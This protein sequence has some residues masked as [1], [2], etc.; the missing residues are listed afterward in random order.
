[1]NEWEGYADVEPAIRANPRIRD[2]CEAVATCE[3]DVEMIL[4][5]LRDVFRPGELDYAGRRWH[6]YRLVWSGSKPAEVGKQSNL[7]HGTVTNAIA[8]A[9]PLA[10][11]GARRAHE[12]L[13][14]KGNTAIDVPADGD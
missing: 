8:W 9:G 12:R 14:L 7:S 11:G 13:V 10:R 5:L 1:M 3:G 6:A 4:R 2:L